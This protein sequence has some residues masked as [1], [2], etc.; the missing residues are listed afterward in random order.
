[1]VIDAYNT[2]QNVRGRSDYLSGGKPGDPQPPFT[3]FDPQ[4]ILT[5]MDA[6]GVDRAFVC[7][8]GQRIENEF[9]IQLVAR[10][11]DRFYGY[12]QVMPQWDDAQEHPDYFTRSE[13]ARITLADRIKE[14]VTDD[15]C[16]L[17]TRLQA[18]MVADLLGAALSEVD[19]FEI[20]DNWL[21]DS[22][23][24]QGYEPHQE[25]RAAT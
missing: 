9:I 1:M 12:G 22:D 16:A 2:T 7:S 6:A 15:L 8:L 23:D 4:R 18:S 14:W 11:P 10:H 24:I 17:P 3:P 21:S 5:R 20:A 25:T 19:W 13:Q